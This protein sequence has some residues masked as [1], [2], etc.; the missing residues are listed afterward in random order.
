[1]DA[2]AERERL[3]AWLREKAARAGAAGAVVGL[4]GG[5]DSAVVGALCRLAFAENCLG[6]IMPC[7]SNPADAEDAR[8]VAETVGLPYRVVPLD[9]VYDS[10]LRALE[11]GE[12]PAG[13]LAAAN[14]KPRLR[15]VTL[16]YFA[17]RHNYLVAGTGN[18]S[19]LFTGYFTKY[20]DGGV[21]LEPI[22][23]LVKTEVRAL[24]AELGIPERVI[25]KPPSAGLWAGQT[26]EGEMGIT[27]AEL[28]HYILTGE[29]EERV[30]RVADALHA[31]AAHKLAAPP[32]P[33]RL[34]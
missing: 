13:G 3:V 24:A 18:R 21:D 16:Y 7:H 6:I 33:E 8:L 1:M 30:R 32:S 5:I 11:G 22:G 9:G 2:A 25:T 10:L 20:G 15:M 26:D 34:A 27:Y 29:A 14:L 4:S 17:N 19:E 28:D 23:H 31:R 12:Q